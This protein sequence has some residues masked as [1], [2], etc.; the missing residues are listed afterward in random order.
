MQATRH[1][2]ELR[3]VAIPFAARIGVLQKIAYSGTSDR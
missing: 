3:V 2:I 1:R